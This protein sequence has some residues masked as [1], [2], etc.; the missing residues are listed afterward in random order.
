MNWLELNNESQLSEI[1]AL[2]YKHPVAIFKHSTRCSISAFVKRAFEKE[3]DLFPQPFEVVLLDLIAYRDVSNAV[4]SKFGVVH[5]SPQLIV[6]Q[7]AKVVYAASHDNIS[8]A[9]AVASSLQV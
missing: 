5:Q 8:A 7:N 3:W 1:E 4:A 2:S 6:V 9:E